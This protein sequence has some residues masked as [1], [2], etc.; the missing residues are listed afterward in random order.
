MRAVVALL[1][2]VIGCGRSQGIPDHDLGG[3][4]VTETR[5]PRQIEVERA[6]TDPD[7]LGRA[8]AIPHRELVALLGEHSV[9]IAVTTRVTENG[10][11]ISALEEKTSI[12]RGPDGGFH[13]VYTNSEDYGREV[14]FV[15]GKLYLRPRYQRWHARDPAPPSEPIALADQYYEPIF[16]TW[17]LFAPGVTTTD[18]GAIDPPPH[19]LLSG[20]AA[21]PGK[22]GIIEIAGRTGRAI[23]IA[24]AASPRRPAPERL[25][26][27]KWRELR[28]VEAITGEVVLDVQRGVPLS[29]NLAGTIRFH[30]DGRTFAMQVSLQ[31]AVA[32]I[33]R[34]AQVEAPPATDVVA[35]P[36][37]M[38]E[39]D[40]RDFLLQGI[41]PP[42][43]RQR[44]GNFDKRSEPTQGNGSP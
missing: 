35:T 9:S 37:R 23:A 27:R 42:L 22:A 18:K 1:C 40:D 39:V 24:R 13:A 34:P 43:H 28:T 44:N 36:E 21:H 15:G 33:G 41:A 10:N 25:T 31:S 7:E 3:L 17:D 32:N 29:V 14:S 2:Q 12:E 8:L 4:V 26:Q 38:K 6:A 5:T 16:A 19:S 20:S 30:R 11:A